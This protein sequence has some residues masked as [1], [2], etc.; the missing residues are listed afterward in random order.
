MGSFVIF[1]PLPP[2]LCRRSI[3]GTGG[4]APC[5]LRFGATASPVDA[6]GRDPGRHA[7]AAELLG[8]RREVIHARTYPGRSLEGVP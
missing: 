2:G 3:R 5:V 4:P 7:L 8:Q 6:T 1:L